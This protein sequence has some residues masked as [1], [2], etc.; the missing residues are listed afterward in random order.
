MANFTRG[1]T[2]EHVVAGE[3]KPLTRCHCSRQGKRPR[4]VDPRQ[5]QHVIAR[6]ARRAEWGRYKLGKNVT[7]LAQ[8]L[9]IRLADVNA[10]FDGEAASAEDYPALASVW[11]NEAD[12]V[13]DTGEGHPMLAAGL[14][15]E[16]FICPD[17]GPTGVDEDGCC[18]TC[19][20]DT[21]IE[22]VGGIDG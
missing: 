9:Q 2:T 6:T 16:Q 13:F 8:P 10:M 19:G 7:D 12:A 17:C 22:K 15:E 20:V 21:T 11:D 5:T 18:T 3:H 14:H 4:T 1:M